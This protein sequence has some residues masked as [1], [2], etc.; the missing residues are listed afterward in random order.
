MDSAL[1]NLQRLICHKTQQ[2]KPNQ[3]MKDM[4][5]I[6]CDLN[7]R[8]WKDFNIWRC[9]TLHEMG[10]SRRNSRQFLQQCNELELVIGNTWF[11]QRNE[12]KST[13]QHFRSKHRHLIDYKLVYRRDLQEKYS[14]SIMKNTDLRTDNC[15]VWPKITLRICSKVRYS[16]RPVFKDWISQN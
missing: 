13:W 16:N 5:I 8:I 10:I 7:D 12:C 3:T 11:Q 6:F 2:I 4:I 9:L 14:A 1:N 15:F